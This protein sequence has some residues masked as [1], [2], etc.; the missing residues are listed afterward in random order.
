MN[1]VKKS[2]APQPNFEY[3]KFVCNSLSSLFVLSTERYGV[4]KLNDS[5]EWV[6]KDLGANRNITSVVTT[7][8]AAFCQSLNDD[9]E[10][11]NSILC[12]YMM[13]Y[14]VRCLDEKNEELI[15]SHYAF[16]TGMRLQEG[17][18]IYG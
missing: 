14:Y 4:V 3:I 15:Y 11:Y 12:D 2:Y 17:I 5:N 10:E 18:Y 7:Y 6:I 13:S 1:K 8:D 9:F 16:I